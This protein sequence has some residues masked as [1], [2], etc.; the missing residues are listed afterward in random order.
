MSQ[1]GKAN[2]LEVLVS[3]STRAQ[4]LSNVIEARYEVL[5][6]TASL[7]RSL[8]YSALVPLSSISGLVGEDS[9]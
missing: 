7:K 3:E 4:A 5:T 8:G 6:L 2:Y 9:P 1:L